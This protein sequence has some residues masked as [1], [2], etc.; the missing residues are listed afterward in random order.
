MAKPQFV[1]LKDDLPN[2][3]LA[4][5]DDKFEIRWVNEDI[6]SYKK[7]IP[8]LKNFPTD[9]IITADDDVIYPEDWAERLLKSYATDGR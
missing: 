9:V 3:L 4:L 7:L 6:R 1:N 2:S 8:A 5:E